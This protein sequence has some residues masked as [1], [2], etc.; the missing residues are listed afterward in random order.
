LVDFDICGF[1]GGMIVSH[2]TGVLA[3]KSFTLILDNGG[4]LG[5]N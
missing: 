4:H 1:M 2:N 5:S 3:E